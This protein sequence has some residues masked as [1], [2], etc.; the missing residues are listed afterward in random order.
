MCCGARPTGNTRCCGWCEN[1]LSNDPFSGDSWEMKR[2]QHVGSS[3]NWAITNWRQPMRK[4]RRAISSAFALLIEGPTCCLQ[5][6]SKN[7]CSISVRDSG[8]SFP[9]RLLCYS[10]AGP[11][12][13]SFQPTARALDLEQSRLS[14]DGTHLTANLSRSFAQDYATGQKWF[15]K[16]ATR[17]RLPSGR[18][19]ECPI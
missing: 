19:S 14:R 11:D 17:V 3:Q 16:R 18:K 1:R 4:R 15:H 2:T 12:Y 7:F 13:F 6:C 9:I 10:S 5:T 8:I